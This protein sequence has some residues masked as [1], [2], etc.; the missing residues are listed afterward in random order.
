MIILA[1]AIILSACTG[2][3]DETGTGIPST[4]DPSVSPTPDTSQ[5]DGVAR[6]FM[7]AWER[8]DYETMYGYISPTSQAEYTL[9]EFTT[10]YS[11]ATEEM[12]LISLEVNEKSLL[13]SPN[14]DTAQLAF[15]VKY[16]TLIIGDII[17][18]LSM[19]LVLRDDV[20]GVVWRP[21]LIFEELAGGG[22]LQFEAETPSRA[23]IYD[24]NGQ[25]LVSANASAVTITIIPGQVGD[26][27][28]DQMLELLS[29]VLRMDPEVIKQQYDSAPS[30]WS[31]ALGDVDLETYQANRSALSSYPALG[32]IDKTGRRYFNVLASHVL[33]YTS[34]IQEDQLAYYQD[35]G[36]TGDEIV[37]QYGIEQWGE[38][39]LAGT[40]GGTLSIWTPGGTFVEIASKD[41]E[42]A[43]SIYTTLDRDLQI[44]VQDAI[45]EAYRVSGET[46]VT[47]AGG[48]AVVVLDVNNGDVLALYSYPTFD[49][50][51]FH[52]YNNHPLSTDSYL[53]GLFTNPF[54]PLLN[55]ATQGAYAPGSLFK[56]VSMTAALES[57]I[58]TVD[59]SYTCT[60]Q[61]NET[62]NFVRYDWL[63]GGH[64]PL[65][66]SQALTASCNPW[67]YHIGYLT[68]QQDYNLIP[69][70]A[71]EYHLGQPLGI[72]LEEVPG[73]IPDPDWL[74]ETRGE[75]WTI[76]DS[77][78]IAIGQGDVLVTPLQM[79]VLIAAIANGG[80]L[81][82]P[83]FVDRI[84]LIAEAPSVITEPVMLG[85]VDISSDT[86]AA[87]RESMYGVTS[88][89]S[90]GT[91]A[92][93]FRGI[94]I[95]VAGKT[96][97]A[98]V[99]GVGAPNA[100]F[101]G[102]APY[103]N[104]EIAVVVLI[105]NGG[106][107]SSVAAPI[108]RRIVEKYYGLTV[109]PYPADWGNPDTFDFVEEGQ[110]GE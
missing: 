45:E 93:R 25:W 83:Q 1:V 104:P 15:Q 2:P 57:G 35:L 30:D 58:F 16:H 56:V 70:Y 92:Y 107:G 5:P 95:P 91:A 46:W 14:G 61:W 31:V 39:Y 67:F 65:T 103:D 102:F 99:S 33:G 48:A 23:N 20:W 71:R 86:L 88:N 74:W 29:R 66:L 17:R 22:I 55:R 60:G 109:N 76:N 4:S 97:T 10:T 38:E 84:G 50:N 53:Q 43:Q 98:Q 69:D 37:G 49:P 77:I 41:P 28:E 68:G 44:I 64:G 11:S 82:Q 13:I 59:S 94:E 42:P 27:Y 6:S 47:T 108:F 100:W 96:G 75:T 90:I 62:G 21:S 105:E 26:S 7:D 106:Q 36:Y 32:A 54:R 73:L 8:G 40:R 3:G 18:D 85:Q 80:T 34:F 87:I 52:P 9:A 24:R 101:G 51:I 89:P 79:A 78:N 81:Y 63:E 12:H 110:V 19:S 72:I